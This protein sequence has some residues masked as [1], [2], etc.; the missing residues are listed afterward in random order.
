MIIGIT[1]LAVLLFSQEHVPPNVTALD[2][3]LLVAITGL[4][5]PEQG[6]AGFGI[7]VVLMILG[8]LIDRDINPNWGSRLPRSG[9]IV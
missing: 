6:F 1:V 4:V 9:D 5:T 7:E 8:L 2:L 3:M